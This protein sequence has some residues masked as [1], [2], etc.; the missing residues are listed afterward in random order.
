MRKKLVKALRQPRVA[1]DHVMSVLRGRWYKFF[2]A[3]TG[4]RVTIGRNF[5]VDG[6]LSIRGPGRVVIGDDVRVGMRVTPWTHEKDAVIEIGNRVFLNGTRFGCAKS[7][8]VGD[9]CILADCRLMDTDHHGVDPR[10]RGEYKSAPIVVGKNVWI[11][12][13]CVVLKGTTIA[14]GCTVTPNSVVAKSLPEPD[15]IYG[16]NPAVFL[17]K[18]A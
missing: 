7:I 2:Y 17:K 5:K 16:G 9:D 8:A 18:A 15:S 3:L 12:I 10:N 13:Q 4:A 6:S 11:T 1:R 14:D